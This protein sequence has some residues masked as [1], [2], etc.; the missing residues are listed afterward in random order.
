MSDRAAPSKSKFAKKK[1][2]CT[3]LALF[4][5]FFHDL[6]RV[7]HY[8]GSSPHQSRMRKANRKQKGTPYNY[9]TKYLHE[10][11]AS[12][13]IDLMLI[14]PI[15]SPPLAAG[16]AALG[17]PCGVVELGHPSVPLP[18]PPVHHPIVVPVI[19]LPPGRRLG[20]VHGPR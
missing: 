5:I 12:G 17:R 10:D 18:R 7:L 4:F 14:S 13:P 6:I 2:I 20:V 16:A 1:L 3:K 19:V 11:T 8:P 15:L 9:K